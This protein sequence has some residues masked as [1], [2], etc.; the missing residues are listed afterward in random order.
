MVAGGRARSASHDPAAGVSGLSSRQGLHRER[1]FFRLAALATRLT[2][3]ANAA[4]PAAS[5]ARFEAAR[6][7]ARF[8]PAPN[9]R[10][11]FFSVFCTG[12][13]STS[14]LTAQIAIGPTSRRITSP[15]AA[16]FGSIRHSIATAVHAIARGAAVHPVSGR[17]AFSV[18]RQ[19]STVNWLLARKVR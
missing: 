12:R 17:L 14:L 4:A 5:Q 16:F 13:V 18:N 11:T 9:R 7:F 19:P 8:A 2:P 1:Y 3:I 15:L 10:S 6:L